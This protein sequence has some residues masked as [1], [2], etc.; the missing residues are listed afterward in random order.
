MRLLKQDKGHIACAK[1]FV[2][3]IQQGKAAPISVEELFEIAR[4]TLSV[5]QETSG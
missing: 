5:G 1:A 3:S 4:V 2:E